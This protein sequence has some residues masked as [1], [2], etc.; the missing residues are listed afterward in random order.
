[1]NGSLPND[2]LSLPSLD[3]SAPEE[4]APE[5]SAL[6]E[7]ALEES[8]LEESVLESATE[9]VRVMTEAELAGLMRERGRRVV[10]SRGRFWATHWGFFRLLHTA[11]TMPAEELGRPAHGCWAFHALLPDQD[12]HQANASYPLHLIRDLSA[13]DESMLDSGARKQLRRCRATL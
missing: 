12:S 2:S 4:S 1:M 13:F 11:A 10:F 5:E 9:G 6:E 7:S 3:K 8:V